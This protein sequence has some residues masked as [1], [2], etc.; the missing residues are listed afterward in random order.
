MG[1]T[2]LLVVASLALGAGAWLAFVWAVKSDHFEDV[3]GPKHRM[4]E[5]DGEGGPPGDGG[6]GR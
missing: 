6:V 2:A 5:D 3:E 4:L 1:T